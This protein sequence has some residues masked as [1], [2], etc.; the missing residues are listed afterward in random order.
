MYVDDL[1]LIATSEQQLQILIEAVEQHLVQIFAA[2]NQSKT[3]FLAR[4]PTQDLT[5]WLD[6][7]QHKISE[8]T[9]YLGLAIAGRDNW[10]TH[11]QSII[12]K[13][14]SKFYALQKKG[15][16][17]DQM[18][19]ATAVAL[20]Q[21]T[22]IP[23]LT[24]GSEIITMSKGNA[25][26]I[27]T[28][29]ATYTKK[30]LGLHQHTP[31]AWVLWEAGIL[32]SQ[33]L[34]DTS[35]LRYWHKLMKSKTNT[36]QKHIATTPTSNLSTEV[37]AIL[38]EFGQTYHTNPN[39]LPGK[40]KWKTMI[41]QW[42]E[43]RAKANLTNSPYFN[44]I[45]NPLIIKPTFDSILPYLAQ[46]H[47]TK[48]ILRLRAQ[49]SNTA[50]DPIQSTQPHRCHM[51]GEESSLLHLT[52]SCEAYTQLRTDLFDAIAQQTTTHTLEILNEATDHQKLEIILNGTCLGDKSL[53]ILEQ[54]S[55]MLQLQMR[56]LNEAAV[57]FA[58]TTSVSE[59]FL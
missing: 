46:P 6:D 50:S 29:I 51:C 4:Q 9:T 48:I 45:L 53:D 12:K 36:I 41:N 14:N 38:N 24:Y 34:F 39:L 35:K 43:S 57:N 13:T 18:D 11:V 16:R 3:K 54:F 10:N 23:T 56:E 2:S 7:R 33:S 59:S 22:L 52:F 26:S 19:P 49:Q 44:G 1:I 5:Q 32:D 21:K 28:A 20:I 27:T 17:P 15:L 25:K 8:S 42:M 58:A 37:Q 30:A 47:N 55:K 31:T 40:K